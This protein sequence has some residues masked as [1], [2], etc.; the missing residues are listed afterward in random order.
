MST[1][2]IVRTCATLN[3][4]YIC[5]GLLQ[6]HGIQASIDNAEHAAVDWSIVQALGGVHI[7][8]PISQYGLAKT[9]IV[10]TVE[11]ARN[12]P[13]KSGEEYE[14]ST[15]SQRRKAWIMMLFWFGVFNTILLFVIIWLEAVIPH[16]W[17]PEPPP[18]KRTIPIPPSTE[19][20]IISEQAETNWIRDN[21]PCDVRMP[22]PIPKGLV[23]AP[24]LFSE[25][26][27]LP[28]LLVFSLRQVFVPVTKRN[29]TN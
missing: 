19:S 10:Q 28:I 16:E 2:A 26:L 25:W 29:S 13:A 14:P 5:R 4:A 21:W 18:C 20:M 12:S 15:R 22:P 1:T 27:V 3:E 23:Y 24:V 11:H 9:T 7:R 17:F 8:V 6:T